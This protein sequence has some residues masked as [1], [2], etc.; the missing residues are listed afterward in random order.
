MIFT[1]LN[2]NSFY[3]EQLKV[4]LTSL[5]IN[6]PNDIANV[7]L[8]DFPE[9]EYEILSSKFPKYK[10]TQNNLKLNKN[11]AREIMVCRRSE[12]IKDA[13]KHHQVVAWFDTDLIIRKSLSNFWGMSK[14]NSILI[15]YRPWNSKRTEYI[16][17]AGIFC[18]N[19]SNNITEYICNWDK[20][21]KQDTYWISEQ[22]NLYLEYEQLKEKIDLIPLPKTFHDVGCS[23]NPCFLKDSYIW[24]SKQAHFKNPKFQTEYQNYLKI[25]NEK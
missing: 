2:F 14:P 23:V 20:K 16:F 18:V 24:H 13:L 17:Q 19:K 1:T 7:E 21:L 25:Y 5:S 22:K 6:S 9:K 10:F 4:M 3:Y 11:N 15:L 8:V 12:I